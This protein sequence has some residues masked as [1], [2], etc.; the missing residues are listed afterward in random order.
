M[1][2]QN[3]NCI[4]SPAK[5]SSDKLESLQGWYLKENHKYK[6]KKS[7]LASLSQYVAPYLSRDNVFKSCC[8]VQLSPVHKSAPE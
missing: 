6:M 7:Y 4:A 5:S 3:T 8:T 2:V 1:L